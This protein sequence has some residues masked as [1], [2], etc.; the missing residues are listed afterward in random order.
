MNTSAICHILSENNQENIWLLLKFVC[1]LIG[2][3][4]ANFTVVKSHISP[5]TLFSVKISNIEFKQF[6]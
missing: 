1:V 4:F 6:K 5:T 3:C 2:L